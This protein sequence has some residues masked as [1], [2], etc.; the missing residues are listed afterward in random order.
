MRC[1][2]RNDWIHTWHSLSVTIWRPVLGASTQPLDSGSVVTIG[3]FDGVHRGH[4]AVI[5]RTGECASTLEGGPFPVVAVTFD[6]H[7]L[8][9]VGPSHVP[10]QLSTMAERVRLLKAAGADHVYVLAFD[11]EMAQWSP[12][13]FVRRIIINELKAAAVVVGENFRFGHKA[14][15]DIET[16]RQC[17]G[18]F[19]VEAI[20]LKGTG[21][22]WSST[23]VRQSLE[24]GDVGAAAEVLGRDY[25]VSGT[26]VRGDQRGRG[27]GF[28]TANIAAPQWLAVP[29]DG[30]YAG[31]LWLEDSSSGLPAAISVGSNPTFDGITRRIES[32]VLDRDDLELYGVCV[33]VEFVQQIRTQ[34]TFESVDDLVAAM[35]EDV[36]KIRTVLSNR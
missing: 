8:T 15:G 10:K 3:T 5:E 17:A 30:V 1:P 28:P 36:A 13:E 4:R 20:S 23:R 21:T 22:P 11:H 18:G 32:Y 7:P 35:W 6:P 24:A 12:E 26:V 34:S 31:H 19:A 27:L 2:V 14:A 29:A 16:L 33:T 9:V 25:G